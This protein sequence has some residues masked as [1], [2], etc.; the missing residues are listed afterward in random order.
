[1]YLYKQKSFSFTLLLSAAFFVLFTLFILC[2][3][4]SVSDTAEQTQADALQRALT[5]SAIHCYAAEGRYPESLEYLQEEYGI[6][7][8]SEQYVVDYEVFASN[9]LPSISVIPLS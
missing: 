1:M 2:K 6:R 5:R 4:N 8:D 3:I 7:W 9:L